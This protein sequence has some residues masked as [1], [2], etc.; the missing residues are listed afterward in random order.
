VWV[1]PV[2]LKLFAVYRLA[3]RPARAIHSLSKSVIDSERGRDDPLS[4]K[5]S[6]SEPSGDVDE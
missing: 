1:A 6:G 3:S 2:G 4:G 5:I